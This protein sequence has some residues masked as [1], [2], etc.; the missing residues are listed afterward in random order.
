MLTKRRGT[1]VF[2]CVY[3]VGWPVLGVVTFPQVSLYFFPAL[4]LIGTFLCINRE[5]SERI[6]TCYRYLPHGR[7]SARHNDRV[8]LLRRIERLRCKISSCHE[9]IEH[10]P[11]DTPEVSHVPVLLA[12]RDAADREIERLEEDVEMM[13]VGWELEDR[14]RQYRKLTS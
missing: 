9:L 6:S 13:R 12:E 8:R 10:T 5:Y 4:F 3:V 1:V 14:E 11:E 2:W 7:D